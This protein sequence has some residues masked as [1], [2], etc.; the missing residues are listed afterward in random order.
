MKTLV[1]PGRLGDVVLL[2]AVTAALGRC[3]VATEPRYHEVASA[4]RGVVEVVD[5]GAARGPDCI[6]LQGGFTGR[7]R[8]PF[9]RR[10]HKR[11]VKRRLWRRL[12]APT[13]LKRPSVTALYGE[14]VGVVPVGPPWIDVPRRVRDTL[15]LVPGAAWEPKR[16]SFALLRA[17]AELHDGPI[18][19]AGGPGEERLCEALARQVNGDVLC[20][21][22]F[23]AC[24]DLFARATLTVAGDT[25]LLHL[26]GAVGSPV[27]AWFG[28]THPDDG[29]FVYPGSVV[30]RSLPCRPCGL[31]R[32]ASCHRGDHACRV[33]EPDVVTRVLRAGLE[34]TWAG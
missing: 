6:D 18:V 1:R 3:R 17:A 8:L 23:A 20:E 33:L 9:A 12:G 4:L 24:I 30:Q 22:G 29:F 7:R 10:I 32:V 5:V 16:P 26:A 19:V 11:S 2:G 34:G 28:P 15:V 13:V 31:H 27:V 21:S 14:A 25:G